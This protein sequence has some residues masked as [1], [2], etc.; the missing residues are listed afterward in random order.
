MVLDTMA[1]PD[2]TIR[3]KRGENDGPLCTMFLEELRKVVLSFP[4][5]ANLKGPHMGR[6]KDGARP[7]L[8]PDGS[9][10]LYAETGPTDDPVPMGSLCLQP[11]HAGSPLF[12]G[13]PTQLQKAGQIKRMIVLEAYCGKGVAKKLI[14]AAEECA[15]NEMGVDHVVVE[16]APFLEAAQALYLKSG[17]RSRE[18]FGVY[19]A[20]E[21][22]CYEK[23]L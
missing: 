19:V 14:E 5:A 22:L 6:G 7:L 20:G 15:R 10:F 8:L 13:L 2:E 17:Y 18:V 16:T 12:K 23:W 3:I 1:N 21:S 4:E 11:L 9:I